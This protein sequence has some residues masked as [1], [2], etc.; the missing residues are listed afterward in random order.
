[1]EALTALARFTP[2]PQAYFPLPKLLLICSRKARDLR[3]EE[4]K[5]F[6]SLSVSSIGQYS[7]NSDC[8]KPSVDT[9]KKK[10]VK[11]FL[12]SFYNDFYNNMH[13]N[14]SSSIGEDTSVDSNSRETGD[15]QHIP[16]N[17]AHWKNIK[18]TSAYSPIK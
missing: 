10:I 17:D 1:M 2:L 16:C 18:E 13:K 12:L 7:T 3:L 11:E 8:S 4:P 6:L 9:N 14:R 5:P 15:D